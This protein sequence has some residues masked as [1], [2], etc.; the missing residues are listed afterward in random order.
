MRGTDARG[1]ARA[2]RRTALLVLLAAVVLSL[3]PAVWLSYDLLMRS[4]YVLALLVGLG[5]IV[6]RRIRGETPDERYARALRESSAMH[7]HLGGVRIAAVHPGAT[8]TLLSLTWRSATTVLLDADGRPRGE[9]AHNALTRAYTLNMP[10]DDVVTAA[11]LAGEHGLGQ[12]S[13]YGTADVV[14]DPSATLIDGHLL[15]DQYDLAFPSW[16][17][18]L[19]LDEALADRD[20]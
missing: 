9:V 3:A 2:R 19:L 17:G 14:R 18:S 15:I 6:R 10:V 16:S 4:S 11:I 8:S 5:L 20:S 13:V 1:R 7:V 12:V